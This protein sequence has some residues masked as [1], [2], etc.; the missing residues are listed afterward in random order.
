MNFK[1]LKIQYP[2]DTD[3]I[4]QARQE[5]Y[6]EII[7]IICQYYGLQ[8]NITDPLSTDNHS[9]AYYLYDFLSVII[10]IYCTIFY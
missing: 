4:E 10:K 7:D 6:Q 8:L 5:T 3:N 2:S 1:D 9:I